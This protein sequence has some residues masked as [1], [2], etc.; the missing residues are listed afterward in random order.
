[1]DSFIHPSHIT[2]FVIVV[3]FSSLLLLAEN[4]R[5][6]S[7]SLLLGVVLAWFWVF[8]A[9]KL[10]D[11]LA[12]AIAHPIYATCYFFLYIFLGIIVALYKWRSKIVDEI[13]YQIKTINRLSDI[14][15]ADYL[16]NIKNFISSAE[17]CKLEI[18]SWISFWPL[19]I[20][21]RIILFLFRDLFNKIAEYSKIMFD[22][23]TERL[24]RNA[25]DS[26]NKTNKNN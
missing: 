14:K 5:Q 22:Y 7:F 20:I 4:A 11:A 8:F 10:V 2:I 19:F 16:D 15:K 9:T 24:T 21:D 23:L 6:V 12:Y 1:M 26:Y 17:N 18:A 25:I 13:N 3:F